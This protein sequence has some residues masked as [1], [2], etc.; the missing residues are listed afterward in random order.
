M[1]KAGV[2]FMELSPEDFPPDISTPS[3]QKKDGNRKNSSRKGQIFH[4]IIL[5]IICA[6]QCPSLSPYLDFSNPE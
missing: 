2:D 4:N 1:N 6:F 3:D 5:L